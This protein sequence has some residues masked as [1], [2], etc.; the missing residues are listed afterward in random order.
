LATWK[1]LINFRRLVLCL[2]ICSLHLRRRE[3]GSGG[4]FDV[5]S[6]RQMALA[7]DVVIRRDSAR[8][9]R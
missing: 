5:C 2:R 3:F 8:K 9:L 4:E 1:Q 6:R 7:P